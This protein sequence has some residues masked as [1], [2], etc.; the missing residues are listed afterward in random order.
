MR[1]DDVRFLHLEKGLELHNLSLAR[2]M[3]PLMAMS[4]DKRAIL[5]R[6]GQDLMFADVALECNTYLFRWSDVPKLSN[7]EYEQEEIANFVEQCRVHEQKLI[8]LLQL[9]KLP[10]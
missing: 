5:F 6:V 10:L 7:P 8:T 3:N 1:E 2:N 9:H 4:V